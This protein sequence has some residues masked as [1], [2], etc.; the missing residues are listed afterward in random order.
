MNIQRLV[1]F[2]G[3]RK[4]LRARRVFREADWLLLINGSASPAPINLVAGKR[5]RFRFIAITPA[6]FLVVTLDRGS[7][8]EVWHAI[9]K[10][11]ATLP[12]EQAA[13]EAADVQ[14]YPGETY[15]FEFQSLSAGELRLTASQPF[16]KLRTAMLI[17][18]RTN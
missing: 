13:V 2:H 15:D 9:A 4:S 18:V 12:P 1:G 17:Q 5:Y 10:D 6:P 11:G 14:M 8:H 3:V 7:Q 16:F